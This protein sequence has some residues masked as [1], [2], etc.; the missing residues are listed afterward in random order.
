MHDTK[1]IYYADQLI[2]QFPKKSEEYHDV[3]RIIYVSRV[4]SVN[5]SIDHDDYSNNF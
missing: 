4:Y 3:R 2:F 5:H 1:E